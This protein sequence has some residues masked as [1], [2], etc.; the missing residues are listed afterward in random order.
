MNENLFP[1]LP[2]VITGWKIIGFVGVALF[3]GRWLVQLY[4][5]RKAG[6]PVMNR[7]FWLMSMSGSFLLLSYFIF[8]KNDSVGVLSNLFPCFVAGYNLYLDIRYHR[9]NGVKSE[10]VPPEIARRAKIAPAK[11]ETVEEPI[12]AASAD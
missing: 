2:I 11:P 5:S 7:W 8:G 9:E 12:E 4:A 3:T 1:S 10:D 6:R